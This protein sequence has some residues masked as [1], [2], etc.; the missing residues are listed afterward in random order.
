MSQ[1]AIEPETQPSVTL[2]DNSE[3]NF[4]TKS[5]G[6]SWLSGTRGV[7]FGICLGIGLTM[8]GLALISSPKTSHESEIV[9]M[10]V[11]TS[12][13]APSVTLTS[14]KTTAVNQTITAIGTVSAFELIPVLSQATGLQIQQVFVEAGDYVQ[15]GQVLAQLDDTIQRAQLAQAQA[16]VAQAEARLAELKAGSRQEDIAQAKATVTRIEFEV[17]QAQSDLELAQTRLERNRT[18]QA[19]GAIAQDRLDEIITEERNRRAILAQKEALLREAQQQ[20]AGL[21][22][23]TR[24]EVIAQA[25]AQLGE[26]K[27]RLQVVQADLRDTKIVAPVSGKIAERNAAV[28]D[29][30][31]SF[32]Q[33]PLFQIIENNRLELRLNVPETQI[34]LIQPGQVVNIRSESDSQLKIQGKIREIRPT[35]NEESRQALVKVDL[36][37]DN[38]LKP[39]MFLRGSIIINTATSLTIPMAAVVPQ[40]DGSSVVY[41][42]QDEQTVQEKS[43]VLG[44]ILENQEVEVKSGLQLGDQLVL[45]G[46]G[47]LNDG[48]QV[49]VKDN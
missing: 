12:I 23:G 44:E 32:N 43:V 31:N 5:E 33:T 25:V 40:P 45:K 36:P 48:D 49:I 17:K 16:Q 30:T 14:V 11:S 21:Q 3:L 9:E 27:A 47:F 39:G 2:R 35:I 4:E 6:K 20:L 19:E 15:A 26:A 34:N 42:L 29:T 22:V 24:P 1:K 38:N 18:L 37:T 13:T 28:G 46:A 7:I 41:V 8:G 10:D